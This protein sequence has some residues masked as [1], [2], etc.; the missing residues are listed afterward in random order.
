MDIIGVFFWSLCC[1]ELFQF[2][3]PASTMLLPPRLPVNTHACKRSC[4]S[5]SLNVGRASGVVW[6]LLEWWALQVL[7]HNT[8]DVIFLHLWSHSVAWHWWLMVYNDLSRMWWG[9][10]CKQK[11]T[12]GQLG[13]SKSE[14][15]KGRYQ[16]IVSLVPYCKGTFVLEYFGWSGILF[17]C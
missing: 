6:L 13:N 12:C 16:G 3:F 11:T 10:N 14:K 2:V 15:G 5:W 7:G 8:T 17:R 9:Q 4:F 1:F